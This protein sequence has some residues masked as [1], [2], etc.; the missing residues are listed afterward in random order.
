MAPLQAACRLSAWA[1]I[2]IAAV[3]VVAAGVVSLMAFSIMEAPWS[4]A[5]F[6]FQG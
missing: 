6:L 5:P 2:G 1:D 4:F 3:V